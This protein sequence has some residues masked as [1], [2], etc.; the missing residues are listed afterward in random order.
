[1][2]CLISDKNNIQKLQNEIT[3]SKKVSIIFL[4]F[5]ILYLFIISVD[6]NTIRELQNEIITL[7]IEGPAM[8]AKFL[9]KQMKNFVF[10]WV[11]FIRFLLKKLV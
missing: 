3:M 1:M 7:R 6:K 9:E 4:L 2:Y 5:H 11:S 8:Y 10:N